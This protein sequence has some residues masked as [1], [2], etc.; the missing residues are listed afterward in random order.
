[1]GTA[2]EVIPSPGCGV[3]WATPVLPS[4]DVDLVAVGLLLPTEVGL[5]AG[6]RVP[7]VRCCLPGMADL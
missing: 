4:H 1:M 6:A 3:G 7:H 2:S 5:R